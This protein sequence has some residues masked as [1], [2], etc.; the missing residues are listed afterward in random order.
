MAT[1]YCPECHTTRPLDSFLGGR[2]KPGQPCRACNDC[3]DRKNASKRQNRKRKKEDQAVDSLRE[4]DARQLAIDEL[5]EISLTTF[6][7]LV[8]EIDGALDVNARVNIADTAPLGSGVPRA[9]ADKVAALLG[10]C[11]GLHWTY[12]CFRARTRTKDA[13]YSYSC[14]QSEDR[15]P[16]AKAPKGER[17]RDTLRMDRFPCSGWLHLSISDASEISVISLKHKVEHVAYLNI[18]LPDRW[19]AYI[20]E[21]ARSQTPGQIWRHILREEAQ[22]R[23]VREID[24]PFR[25]KSVYY[26]WATVCRSEW[27]LSDTPLSS[28]RKFLHERGTEFNICALNI[29]EEPGTEVLAFYVKDFVEEWARHTQELGIDSTWNTNG[30]NFELFAAVAD[31]DGAGIPLAFLF[32]AT[33]KKADA[34]AKQA[35]LERFLSELKLLGVNPEFTLS[36]KDWSEI[37]AMR[38]TWGSAKHQLCFWH[39][40]RAVKQRLS[41]NKA[42][43]APYDSREAHRSFDFIDPTFVPLGQQDEPTIP[44]PDPPARPLPRVRLLINGRPPVLTPSL[45]P[46]VLTAEAIAKA[47]RDGEEEDLEDEVGA[48]TLK[49]SVEESETDDDWEERSDAGTYWGDQAEREAPDEYGEEDWEI[50]DIADIRSAVQKAAQETSDGDETAP[51]DPTELGPPPKRPD[52]QFCPAAHRLPVLRLFAKHASQHPLLPE[53]HGEARTAEDI[54]R[55]A[56]YEMYHHCFANNLREVWAYLWSSWYCKS[57]WNLWARAA[58][59]TSIPCKRTTMMV[60]ALWRNLKRLV[61]HMYNRPPVDLAV[62]AL[63][64]QALPS[65]R[66]KLRGIVANPR[67]G[68]P[69]PLSAAQQAMKRSWTR[70]RKVP[71]RGTYRTDIS[72]WTCDCGAQKYHAYLLCKHLVKATGPL[73][74]VW[75]REARRFHIPPFY[76]VP[77]NGITAPAPES[78]RDHAWVTRMSQPRIR[79]CPRAVSITS[80]DS[81]PD[82][83]IPDIYSR[84][85]SPA[86]PTGRDGLLRTQAG[87]GGG[88]ELDD[89]EDTEIEELIRLLGRAIKI[90]QEQHDPRFLQTAKQRLRG[91]AEWDIECQSVCAERVEDASL[92]DASRREATR[93]HRPHYSRERR[94]QP[95]VE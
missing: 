44:V 94:V 25:S 29:K 69:R 61:L 52:Y 81:D 88:F 56:V 54:H 7:N 35:V 39:A 14:A 49:D 19:K 32:I 16:N 20:R 28:A 65:Y 38:M 70:L 55:D 82:V 57:R 15:E 68:R 5:D 79:A 3:R 64:T 75:W 73:P 93:R 67:P 36:D 27:R 76:A 12:E 62:Y 51:R 8:R 91:A 2:Q 45:P 78:V 37:N 74:T 72:R 41:K 33:S 66:L 34:G 10:D 53:R 59:P 92:E 24:V 18:D 43:P 46:I 11:L 48:T 6:V 60:E 21:H 17:G 58:Y 9:R 89:E 87:S 26:Y 90:L 23:G 42:T 4:D 47:L 85:S 77:I 30:G 80:V 84:P 95:Q 31:A 1:K 63:V 71:I 13:V 83:P 40:L 86:P 50:D 22:S